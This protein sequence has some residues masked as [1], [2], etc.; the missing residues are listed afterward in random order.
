MKENIQLNEYRKRHIAYEE[1]MRRILS[2]FS[3]ETTKV[4]GKK[5][6]TSCVML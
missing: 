2:D 3:S 1:T 4:K 5:H 6:G